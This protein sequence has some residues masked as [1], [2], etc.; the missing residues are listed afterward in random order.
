MNNNL[1]NFCV[2]PWATISLGAD[3]KI[4]PCCVYNQLNGPNINKGDTFETA[5]ASY[6]D[7]REQL[8]RDEKP[9]NCNSC[10]EREAT[11]GLS[12]RLGFKDLVKDPKIRDSIDW[13]STEPDIKFLQMDL[14][15]GNTCNLKCRMCS[16][17]L[18]TAWFKEDMQLRNIPK[19][20]Y[21]RML[22][23]T[24]ISPTIIP[25]EYWKDKK[26][27]FENLQLLEFK[28]GEPFMQEGMFV[29]L[30][31]LVEWGLSDKINLYYTTNGSKTP[32]ELKRLWP[33]FK[34]INVDVSIEGTGNLYNY[35]RGSKVQE[36]DDLENNLRFFDQFENVVGGFNI[37]ISI[38]NIFDINNVFQWIDGTRSRG[39]KRFN[40]DAS[41]RKMDC[42]VTWPM[43][44]N[45]N[46]MPP[47]LKKKAFRKMNSMPHTNLES[48]KTAMLNEKYHE[49]EW[50]LFIKFT[51]DLDRIR[52]TDVRDVVPEL[53]PYF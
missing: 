5:W 45:I 30:E 51:K 43:Y 25:A 18:S 19:N 9:S 29:F 32:I 12:R 11:V 49:Y 1:K 35:I 10:W 34:K 13:N 6:K 37:A 4:K 48:L 23:T 41:K 28:G 2:S 44:L 33:Y 8:L 16:S 46:N 42:L 27:Y 20:P 26:H 52:N 7:L 47:K 40:S 21:R 3:G 39:L 53:I 14:N 15:F 24:E 17:S 22:S 36:F 31:Y 38:Y 50:K